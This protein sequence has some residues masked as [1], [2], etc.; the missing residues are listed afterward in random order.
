M[1]GQSGA[2]LLASYEA[3]ARTAI[4]TLETLRGNS[5]PIDLGDLVT[6]TL[7]TIANAYSFDH[8]THLRADIFGPL[9]S[10]PSPSRRWSTA[11]PD[12]RA[13]SMRWDFSEMSGRKNS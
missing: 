13:Y 6:Y 3:N 11:S 8:F 7:G 10:S 12:S 4:A 2:E 5:S 9:G 1:R